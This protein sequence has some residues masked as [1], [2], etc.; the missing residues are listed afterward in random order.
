M[1]EGWY[2][3]SYLVLFDESEVPVV[4]ERYAISRSLPGYQVLG[5][6]GWDDFIVRSPAG[7][8]Y[9]VPTVPVDPKYLV[10]FQVLSERQR[11]V[12]DTRY[13]EKSKWYKRPIAFGGDAAPGENLVCVNHEEHSQLVR[14]WN[15]L[16]RSLGSPTHDG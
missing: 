16:Y 11:L 2:S 14:G 15:D 3:D 4:S 13:S 9:S 12:P 10:P 6:L 5:L 1:R 8:V 7:R